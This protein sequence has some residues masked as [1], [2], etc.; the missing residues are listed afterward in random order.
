MK[1]A[2]IFPTVAAVFSFPIVAPVFAAAAFNLWKNESLCLSGLNATSLNVR[3]DPRFRIEQVYSE[4]EI[5][6]NDCLVVGF[7]LMGQ[8]STKDWSSS[9]PFSQGPHLAHFPGV[10][11]RIEPQEPFSDL[12]I[13]Y[14]IWGLE[15]AILD[16]LETDRFVESIYELHWN[17]VTVGIIDIQRIQNPQASTP[18]QSLDGKVSNQS[19][20][21][22]LAVNQ[23][24]SIAFERIPGAQPINP[25]DIWITLFQSQERLAYPEAY[26]IP[27]A[28]LQLGPF[29]PSSR[30]FF[31]VDPLNGPDLPR[32][33][34][35]F[36]HVSTVIHALMLL[37][38]WMCQN[39]YFSD[40]G[41]TISISD[42][43]V[44]AGR[45][46][47]IRRP[48]GALAGNISTS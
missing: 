40:F 3:P 12:P 19:L 34:P 20:T 13:R 35:P 23:P 31:N 47:E 39:N 10:N 24:I 48:S 32:S 38:A 26:L 36:L 28:I 4:D 27:R 21:V 44:G 25:R 18:R 5:A 30:A 29:V 33:H 15:L 43:L 45:M 17:H 16:L 46:G 6:K 9:V 8:L 22:S 37:A 2:R 7:W 14:A 1:L 41:F 42:T 11:I